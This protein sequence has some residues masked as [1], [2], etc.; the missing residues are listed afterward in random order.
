MSVLICLV[1]LKHMP[2]QVGGALAPLFPNWY[3]VLNG[4][5]LL[6][7]FSCLSPSKPEPR[8]RQRHDF[9]HHRSCK[10][11]PTTWYV[12][13]PHCTSTT[14]DTDTATHCRC[15][16]DTQIMNSTG[17][18]IWPGGRK[19]SP[20]RHSTQGW[21]RKCIHNRTFLH[22]VHPSLTPLS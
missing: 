2:T 13:R 12:W 21:R 8:L 1:I 6:A 15:I 17:I 16:N 3:R 9:R 18:G 4:L 11:S 10:I 7:Y 5:M 22:A 20:G 14:C 19:L